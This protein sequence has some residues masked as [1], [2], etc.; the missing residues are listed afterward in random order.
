MTQ[1]IR[2]IL[3]ALVLGLVIVGG[4]FGI[5]F[6]TSQI[7]TAVVLPGGTPLAGQI[8]WLECTVPQNGS[9]YELSAGQGFSMKYSCTNTDSVNSHKLLV[10][11]YEAD[12]WAYNDPSAG[13]FDQDDVKGVFP[14]DIPDYNTAE[15]IIG[16]W[17]QG[18]QSSQCPIPPSSSIQDNSGTDRTQ[19]FDL[20]PLESVEIDTARSFPRCNYYQW[21]DI[22]VDGDDTNA[23]QYLDFGVVRVAGNASQ[24][25]CPNAVEEEGSLEIKVFEDLNA[26]H[27]YGPQ[28]TEG[29]P[30]SGY[31]LEMRDTA[32]L[33]ID[34]QKCTSGIQLDINGTNLC[35]GLVPGDYTVEVMGDFS[36]YDTTEDT[37][38]NPQ[39]LNPITV[40]VPA[41]DKGIAHF[42][43]VKRGSPQ[44]DLGNLQVRIWEE[45]DFQNG[46]IEYT[47]PAAGT[48][49]SDEPFENEDVKLLSGTTDVTQQYCGAIITGGAGRLSCDQIPVG[50]YTVQVSNPDA[51]LFN[52]PLPDDNDNPSAGEKHNSAATENLTLTVVT[53]P[54]PT[55]TGSD[56]ITF[57][58]FGYQDKTGTLSFC[59]FTA[60]PSS[61]PIPLDVNFDASAST[62]V[63]GI[64]EYRWDFE[65]DGTIDTRTTVPTTTH[66]YSVVG[67]YTA[68]LEIINPDLQTLKC[69]KPIT[70]TGGQ[71]LSC[72][73]A[74]TPSPARGQL[75]LTV[76]FTVTLTNFPAGSHAYSFDPGDGTAAQSGSTSSSPFDIVYTYPDPTPFGAKTA[77]VSFNIQRI[78]CSAPI[79]LL[80]GPIQGAFSCAITTTPSPARGQ[81]PLPV[82]FTVTLTGFP[83]G[84]HAYSFD[85]G[86]G[87]A[88]QSGSTSSSPFDINYTYPDP[89]PFGTKTAKVTFNVGGQSVECSAPV[90]L[91]APPIVAQL[92]C[93]LTAVPNR[94]QAP[95]TTLLTATTNFA[96]QSPSYA[97]TFGDSTAGQTT[98][99]PSVSHI[100]Q[101]P[102]NYTA[103]VTVTTG[104]LTA[105]CDVD[106]QVPQPPIVSAPDCDIT[107]TVTD[108]DETNV[109]NNTASPGELMTYNI[110]WTC[111]NVP[112][113]EPGSIQVKVIITDDYLENMMTVVPNSI[114]DAGID[115]PPVGLIRWTK[116]GAAQVRSGSESF[117]VQLKSPLQPGTYTIPNIAIISGPRGE[118]DRDT[119]VTTI[120]VPPGPQTPDIEVLKFV[121]D[122][123]G[124]T[125]LPG[126]TL[127]YTVIVWNAGNTPLTATVTENVQANVNSFTVTSIP[128]GA[129]DS[130]LPTGGT[131]GTGFLD[132]RNIS[133][134]AQGSSGT[135]VFTVVVNSGVP[136]GT[137]L[138]NIVT[139]TAGTVS[140]SDDEAVVVGQIVPTLNPAP[141]PTGTNQLPPPLPT[142]SI[143]PAAPTGEEVSETG[144]S[145]QV[146]IL[147]ASL[148]AAFAIA[149]AVI[150]RSRHAT[151]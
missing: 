150:F 40:N 8:S 62:M 19:N 90:T 116:V 30:F 33:E 13:C 99:T 6:L 10:E 144:V 111:T 109:E 7:T 71:Q 57:F 56:I 55:G 66:R 105:T 89:T 128:P 42:G 131:N 82:K 118:L 137:Q 21:D 88:A 115:G 14:V 46:E 58:D 50:Q 80:A 147:L 86:D 65:N 108:T 87:T 104:T 139:A 64:T 52:G 91:L 45:I 34:S 12:A 140:D 35:S 101:R 37:V 68:S 17:T 69:T 39:K 85:P 129:Q 151:R 72:A 98:T 32:G 38:H 60:T 93:A 106:I 76:K 110:S 102:G 3:V 23:R 145:A 36:A 120:I 47:T 25:Q 146:W 122:V 114:S 18:G 22:A 94:G 51:N 126:D 75:P 148:F 119:T 11:E 15:R 135:I 54:R 141:Q 143:T 43:Y 124:G 92:T 29:Q 59:G 103:T 53:G 20:A 67:S 125:L 79:T 26:D 100:Y 44:A 132:I 112:T 78:E 84:S 27:E 49:G 1:R 123:N 70:V 107:K 127:R 63:G 77:K 73:I 121:E 41:N 9:Q 83:A 133:L 61:G 24:G 142:Y 2:F 16:N 138:L 134:P 31:R 28:G 113:T 5:Y 96:P 4:G 95:L 74:T 130:S 97:W 136:A 117:R 81:L 149:G 48:N